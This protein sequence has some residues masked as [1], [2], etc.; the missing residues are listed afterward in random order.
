MGDAPRKESGRV[1]QR[2]PREAVPISHTTLES[3]P[4][5]EELVMR[6][7]V[8]RNLLKLSDRGYGE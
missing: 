6:S 5:L 3:I 2:N 7:L 1:L 4:A 8:S